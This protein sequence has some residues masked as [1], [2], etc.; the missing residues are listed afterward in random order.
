MNDKIK[1]YKKL[2]V[3][4]PKY[5]AL[6]GDIYTDEANFKTAAVYYKKAIENGVPAYAALGDTFDYRHQYKKAYNA[7]IKGAEEDETECFNRLAYCYQNG[8]AVKKDLQKAIEYYEKAAD[9]GSSVAA[10]NLGDLYYFETPI[11]DYEIDNIKKALKFYERAFC[12]GDIRVAKKIGF[13]YLN[14]ETLQ[15]IP[16]A[17]EWYEKGLSLG[18]YS[19]NFDLAYVYLNDRF[20][21]HDY[22]KGL[23]Y[24]ADGVKHN[25]PESL[26]LQARIYEDGLC[27][28]EP[29]EKKYIHYLKKAANL[30][31]DDALLD[32]GYYYYKKGKYDDALD[33]FA[34]CD[35]D[36]VGV[37][38]CMAT[39]Y[40]TKK[41]DY[42]NALFYYQM[43]MEM[44]FPDAI[45]RMAEAY[46]GDELGLEKDEK[47]ALKLFKRAAKLGNPAAQYAR[48]E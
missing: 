18:D 19:L 28:I 43:A 2:A 31:Q 20:V 37:Y 32:L 30:C 47:T 22:E 27:G 13:I 29:D 26:Y 5:Y 48:Q 36:Y 17:I 25:D 38:W 11:K 40:E 6:I 23:K 35:L 44:N 21:P 12:L 15:N 9:L 4:K 24:L 14:D 8:H 7:Y 46:L 45:E 3:K 1:R 33:C 34:E 10:R 42:K 16:K 41:A 39:I